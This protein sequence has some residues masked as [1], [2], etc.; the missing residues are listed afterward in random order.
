MNQHALFFWLAVTLVAMATN[1]CKDDHSGHD[2]SANTHQSDAHDADDHHGHDHETHAAHPLEDD[3]H[4]ETHIES[5]THEG[6]AHHDEEHEDEVTV[7]PNAMQRWGIRT[8]PLRRHMMIDTLTV[9]ARVSFNTEA[10]AHIG[11]VVSGRVSQI[12]IRIGDHVKQGDVLLVIASP[13]IGQAQSRY[14]QKRS[15][16]ST[17]EASLNVAKS[18]YDRAKALYDESQGIALSDVQ[19]RE[20]ELHAAQGAWVAAR[21]ALTA[22]KSALQVLGMD[23]KAIAL[24]GESGE[25]DPNFII[26]APFDGQIIEREATLGEAVGPDREA[27][28]VLADLSTLWIIAD[29]PEVNI[30]NIVIGSTATITVPAF[31]D[32]LFKGTVTYLGIQLNTATRTIPVRIEVKNTESL[33]RPG[34]F[35]QV[36][37]VA[38]KAVGDPIAAIPEVA[39][40]TIEGN[41]CVFVPVEGEPN[42]FAKRIVHIGSPIGNKVPLLSGLRADEHYVA[43]GSFILKADLGKAGA[44]HEH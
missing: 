23:Q 34:M 3:H 13:E 35:A 20:A 5:D 41:T 38:N 19:K 7:T 11:S 24:L 29:V 10:V 8:E 31:Q 18:L 22:T 40:Q 25:I 27:L 39:V 12:K 17:T 28:N 30:G 6:H 36:K 16:I 9:P 33:L 37:L 14:L 42:T 15:A 4:D 43:H 32:R 21:S 1:G 26:R 44:A 2:H